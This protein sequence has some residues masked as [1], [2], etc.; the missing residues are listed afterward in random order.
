[1]RLLLALTTTL[2]ANWCAA[3]DSI[4]LFPARSGPV[5]DSL[6]FTKD[7]GSSL[8]EARSINP[9]NFVAASL[10]RRQTSSCPYPV[11]CSATTCCP[12]GTNCCGTGIK[13][14]P[15]TSR[16]VLSPVE[17]CCPNT[18]QTCGGTACA[19]PGSVC[20]GGFVCPS[21]YQC[22]TNG[23]R[24]CCTASEVKCS[25]G[26]C[27]AGSTCSST[28][29]LCQRQGSSSSVRQSTASPV[30]S[31]SESTAVSSASAS[32]SASPGVC[33]ESSKPG[34]AN[35]NYE[36]LNGRWVPVVEIP[37]IAGRTDQLYISMCSGIKN[38][39]SQRGGNS[40]DWDV[41]T[42]AGDGKSAKR[43][44][45]RAAKCAGYCA[46]QKRIF[47]DPNRLECDEYPPAMSSEG[48]TGAFRTCIPAAQ[49]SGEQG[50]RFS[51]F[52]NKCKPSKSSSI[53]VRMRGGCAGL[54]KRDFDS[55]QPL[56]ARQDSASKSFSASSS[57]LRD[58]GN[59]SSFIYVPFDDL[60]NGH[61]TVNA[62]FGS[63]ITGISVIDSDGDS[64]YTTGDTPI[65]DDSG[66]RSV[67][68]Y[69]TDIDD[70]D[71]MPA[72]LIIDTGKSQTISYSATA[73][74]AASASASAT[75]GSLSAAGRVGEGMSWGE[76]LA[77][78]GGSVWVVWE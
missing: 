7:E 61:Y 73:T 50:K 9:L 2:F 40:R 12:S 27:P 11:R 62:T 30:T 76:L 68:F 17:G 4:D 32:S 23:G 65:S 5:P 24:S 52:V 59:A 53:I 1:M 45:R 41:L 78:V 51:D 63:D 56:H 25:G 58:I 16:C 72:A 67:D 31:I 42:Y 49:N 19:D 64:Y 38:T 70:G 47:S 48:G 36:C 3:A 13:C 10:G 22:N 60:R 39:G 14:C 69:V 54:S 57:Q 33:S 8:V 46:E 55:V 21:G 74:P 66:K 26:C 20:C 6:L 37:N 18:A 75:A 28:A 15:S 77:V 43:I 71:L 44:R 35:C 34:R 29:G